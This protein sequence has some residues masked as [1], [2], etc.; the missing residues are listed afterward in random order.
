M[1]AFAKRVFEPELMDAGSCDEEKLLRTI[2]QFRLINQF[3]TR[4]RW[5]L[6]RYLMAEVSEPFSIVDVGAGGGDI[7]QWL[8]GECR[9][10][11]VQVS[12]TCLDTDPRIVDFATR[13]CSAYPEISVRQGDLRNLSEVGRFDYVFANHLLHHF[14]DWAIPEVLVKLWR[15]ANRR[16]IINDLARSPVAYAMYWGFAGLFLRE[17]FAK[18]DGLL[19]IRKGFVPAELQSFAESAGI[20]DKTTI[21]HCSPARL[22]MI[23]EGADEIDGSEAAGH[24]PME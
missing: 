5:V 20:G 22:V 18:Y 8:V 7:M 21:L 13:A 6:K 16:L 9:R 1:S 4:S 19:S 17:S 10:R 3:L 12:V 23:T 11:N 24:C 2:R 14:S 15:V